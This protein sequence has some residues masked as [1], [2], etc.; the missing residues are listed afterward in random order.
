MRKEITVVVE[1]ISNGYLFTETKDSTQVSKTFKETKDDLFS[2]LKKNETIGGV[3]ENDD[4]MIILDIIRQDIKIGDVP[5]SNKALLNGVVEKE[6]YNPIKIKEIDLEELRLSVNK[7]NAYSSEK[8]KEIDFFEL[9]RQLPMNNHKKAEICGVKDGT[10]Y[11]TYN[12]LK[13]GTM[14]FGTT[15]VRIYMT[16]LA[17]FYEMSLGIRHLKKEEIERI[18]NEVELQITE[19]TSIVNKNC[20]ID[21]K[22][23]KPILEALKH[24]IH[25]Q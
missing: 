17:K 24:S 1:K 19:L 22:S 9:D 14:N 21:S 6:V 12:N 25:K 20:L 2:F 16:V 5:I 13:K 11:S 7:K 10:F 15:D 8:L 4:D 18:T 23:L 3:I